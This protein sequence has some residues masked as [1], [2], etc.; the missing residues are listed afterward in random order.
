MILGKYLLTWLGLNLELSDRVIK[1][2]C[3]P[4][5][6]STT[7]MVDL[8]TYE[9][10]VLNKGKITPIELFTNSY[11]EEVFYSEH[12]VPPLNDYVKYYI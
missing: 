6:G 2:D 7:P 10:K 8:S 11:V 12:V 3:G 9:F 5:K 1:A 4:F